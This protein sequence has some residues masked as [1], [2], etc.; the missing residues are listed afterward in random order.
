MLA[1][2]GCLAYGPTVDVASGLPA[3][4]AVRND[5]ATIV[6]AWESLDHLKAHLSAPHMLDFRTRVAD[7]GAKTTLAVLAPV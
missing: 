4:A 3:Q 2:D 7:M 1:E 6:E 5:T